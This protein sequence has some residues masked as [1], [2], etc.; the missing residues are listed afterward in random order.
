MSRQEEG[1][2]RS[3]GRRKRRMQEM[4]LEY[5]FAAMPADSKKFYVVAHKMVK[6]VSRE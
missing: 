1:V 5:I 6:S 2:K 4:L 3:G